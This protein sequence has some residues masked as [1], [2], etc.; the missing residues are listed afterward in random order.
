[1]GVRFQFRTIT[2]RA[3]APPHCGAALALGPT[4]HPCWAEARGWQG[5][6]DRA[7]TDSCVPG[8]PT[9]LP[10]LAPEAGSRAMTHPP[11][12]GTSFPAGAKRHGVMMVGEQGLV[13]WLRG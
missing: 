6:E 11:C 5:A 8:S 13:L 10:H 7:H 4:T 1:M 12:A 2:L 9:H 3:R